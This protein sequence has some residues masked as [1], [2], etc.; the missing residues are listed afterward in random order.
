MT[1]ITRRFYITYRIF[2]G[3]IS[4]SRIFLLSSGEGEKKRARKQRRR[5]VR[6]SK[7]NPNRRLAI[8]PVRK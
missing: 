6:A 2:S 3:D 7:R 8:F 4:I 1:A 5:L